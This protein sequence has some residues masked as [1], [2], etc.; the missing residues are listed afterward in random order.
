MAKKATKR[1]SKYSPAKIFSM[2]LP[3]DLREAIEKAAKSRGHKLSDEIAERLRHSFREDRQIADQ[4]GGERTASVLRVVAHVLQ[5]I[6]NPDNDA[7]WLEDWK[8]FERAVENIIWTLEIV[9]PKRP[10]DW[11]RLEYV[12]MYHAGVEH[13]GY[14]DP[15]ELS[16]FRPRLGVGLWQD[17]VQ[18]DPAPRLDERMTP[19]QILANVIKNK[20]P[21]IVERTKSNQHGEPWGT[22]P[23]PFPQAPGG[24]SLDLP[25][26][27][28]ENQHRRENYFCVYCQD[29][30]PRK[31]GHCP[32]C[33]GLDLSGQAH[34]GDRVKLKP[35]PSDTFEEATDQ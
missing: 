35:I 5:Q 18:A 24:A 28:R 12:R 9:Q 23:S 25:D 30:Y 13:V 8:A 33:K 14:E 11:R 22:P 6:R 29:Y 10:A 21:D 1:F 17:I 20:I 4:F 27:E 19:R 32:T 3:A 31:R 15:A 16:I 7:D 26:P 2:R 34:G